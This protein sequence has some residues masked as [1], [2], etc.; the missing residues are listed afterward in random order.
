MKKKLLSI[1]VIV[2]SVTFV[3]AQSVKNGVTDKIKVA[4]PGVIEIQRNKSAISQKLISINQ[5]T[6]L[7]NKIALRNKNIHSKR[8]S[9]LHKSKQIQVAYL[10]NHKSITPRLKM[11][12]SKDTTFYEGFESYNGTTKDWIPT[13]WTELNKTTTKYVTGDSLNPTWA[14]NTENEYTVPTVGSSMAWVDYDQD[15]KSQDVWL[16]SPAFTPVSGDNI[17]F[18]FFYN[19]FWMY[20]D[21]NAST[22][23]ETIYNFTKANATMQLYITID[24]GV[25]W[26][27]LWDAIDGAGQFNTANIEDW[28]LSYG[29]WNTIQKSLAAYVGKSVKIAFR[30]VGKDGDS[31]GLD[32]IGVRQL[33]PAALYGRP[34][35]YFFAG[36]TTDFSSAS[37]DFMFGHAFDPATWN[38]YSNSDS[39]SF[40][41]TFED[42][43]NSTATVTS[44]VVQ[45]EMVYSVGEYKMPTLKAISGARDSVYSWGSSSSFMAGGQPT[46]SWGT[47]GVGNYDLGQY[48]YDFPDGTTGNYFF[49]TCAD[50]TVD[51]VANYFEKPVH[52]YIL[53]SLWVNLA[54]F[55]APPGTEFKL[56]IRR[57]TDGSFADTIATAV[58]TTEDVIKID[59]NSYSMIFKGFTNID[60]ATGL[61][62]SNDYLEISDAIFVELT[63]FNKKGITLATYAQG[64]DSPIGESN[65]YVFYNTKNADNT[66]SRDIYNASDYIGA[67]TS[68]LFNLG[69]TYSYLVPDANTF[70]API[71][72]GNKTFNVNSWFSPDDWWLDTPLPTWL[73]SEQTFNET[74]WAITYTLKAA[75]LPV[76]IKGRAAS[77]KVATYGADMTI[78]VS[79]GDVTGVPELK[80]SD[81]KVLSKTHSFD[82]SY[83]PDFTSVTVYNVSGQVIANYELPIA[84]KLVIPS[85]NMNKGLYLFRFKGQKTETVKALR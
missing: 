20:V 40:L 35:G 37:S 39:E 58:C 77:V 12:A 67:Y 52:R 8:I 47:V 32:N 43:K 48:I 79:Q 65:A 84:G 74:T 23:T 66:Y 17:S 16:V 83:T 9:M 46:F 62:V 71:T 21:W 41:W 59:D 44:T 55:S 69:A 13:N 70:V 10:K 18:D 57:V 7:R 50:S 25:N 36:L 2:I 60:P 80:F 63:G 19:P 54:K 78:N 49:G 53:D 24:N 64:Y 26:T 42:P 38:N 73:T 4:H 76:G 11:P 34:E 56:I 6:V 30:Y 22:D 14:V 27:K 31:M 68:L 75:A 85:T 15:S 81:T 72:G 45:P 33:L 28:Y 29:D 61:E 3:V 51:A 5:R 82:L 1:V